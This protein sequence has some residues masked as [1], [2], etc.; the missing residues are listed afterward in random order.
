MVVLHK[1][2]VLTG[3]R[4]ALLA[5]ILAKVETAVEVRVSGDDV[6]LVIRKKKPETV[7]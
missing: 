4:L 3:S 2:E 1:G 6:E 7:P 5:E